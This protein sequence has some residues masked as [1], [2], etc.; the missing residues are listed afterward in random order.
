V[1]MRGLKRQLGE[2]I[3]PDLSRAWGLHGSVW[4][5]GGRGF[6]VRRESKGAL[7]GTGLG[8]GGDGAR[9][10]RDLEMETRPVALHASR[11]G[12]DRPAHLALRLL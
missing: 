7:G 5:K 1:G 6:V 4:K 2:R 11:F 10:W 9:G 3:G 12:L 8:R